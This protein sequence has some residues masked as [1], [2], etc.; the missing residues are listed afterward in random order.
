[1]KLRYGSI[2]VAQVE[3]L[4]CIVNAGLPQSRFF[5]FSSCCGQGIC[6][7]RHG[8]YLTCVLLHQFSTTLKDEPYR[9][10]HS[11]CL[12]ALSV[13]SESFF[14][15]CIVFHVASTNLPELA[16][17]IKLTFYPLRY[18]QGEGPALGTVCEGSSGSLFSNFQL[19]S[20]SLMATLRCL[21]YCIHKLL[22]F[23]FLTFSVTAKDLS[24][25]PVESNQRLLS[26]L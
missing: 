20:A 21:C 22:D 4:I 12:L 3:S 7:P 2:H 9:P 10:E 13:A 11:P 8:N 15:F 16:H 1:M 18:F 26:H 24:I 19:P 5:I 17:E 14:F 23:P 6:F 25:H